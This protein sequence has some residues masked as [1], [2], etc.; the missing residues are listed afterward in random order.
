MA[1]Y[2]CCG[3][4]KREEGWTCECDWDGWFLCWEQSHPSLHSIPVY[5]PV[6]EIPNKDGV[7]LV[8]VFED[9]DDSELESEFSTVEK[10]WGEYTNEAISRW[11]IEY[12][13]NWMGF[14]GVYAW[15]EKAVTK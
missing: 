14:R 12:N 4:K 15:K 9:G 7:Y 10:N 13:D 6:K 11:K 3:V 1:M 2:C 8:R 5:V